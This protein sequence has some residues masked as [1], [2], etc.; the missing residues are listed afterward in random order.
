[1]MLRTVWS[2]TLWELRIGML[3]WGIGLAIL[4][5]LHFPYYASLSLET[6]NAMLLYGQNFRF[7]GEPV[8]LLTPGGYATWHTLGFVPVIL[9]IWTVLVGSRLVRGE[10]ERGSLDVVLATSW[11]RVRILAEKIAAL[12]TAVLVIS[13]LFALGAVIGEASAGIQVDIAGAVLAG[14]NIGVTVF[15]FG[16]LALLLSH[17]LLHQAAA[18]GIASGLMV[19]SYL[20]NGLGRIVEHGEWIQYL[21]PLYYYDMSKPLISTYGTNAGALLFLLAVGMLFALASFPL[22]MTRDIS[23][24]ALPTWKLHLWDRGSRPAIQILEQ[25]RH[26]ISMRTVVSRALRAQAAAV[27]WWLLALVAFVGYL[28]LISRITEDA[29][30][31][32]LNGTPALAQFFSGYD[33][34]TNEGILAAILSMYLPAIAVLFAMTQAITW[35]SDLERGRVEMVLSTPQSRWRVVL[36]RF[37][38]VFLALVMAPCITLLTILISARIAGL[39]LE[40]GHVAA[41]SFGMLPLELITAA[42]I[43]LLAVWVRFVAV[44]AITSLLLVLFYFAELL[45]PFLKLPDWLLSLSVFH[46]YGNP[47]VDGPR[48]GPWLILVG[49]AMVFLAHAA[50]RFSRRDVQSAE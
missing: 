6:R 36:E 14:V 34:A 43:Y 13:L 5:F 45:N 16:M 25:A 11:P 3:G 1:M 41:A 17:L 32:M 26:D 20:L 22:F 21:S 37:S 15:L 10:E 31:N 50:V 38:A 35:S 29:I 44:V 33:I 12:L 48:W 47:L 39:R 2:K 8:A 4:I 28:L 49:I 7:L 42:F 46:Q 9:G 24:T 19:L 30:R 23:G 27:T 18:A 40:S